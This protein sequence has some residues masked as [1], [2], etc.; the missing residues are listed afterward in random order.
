MTLNGLLGSQ[1]HESDTIV[2]VIDYSDSYVAFEVH[3]FKCAPNTL[4][5]GSENACLK[6][7]YLGRKKRIPL[8]HC[9]ENGV[10][11]K[12]PDEC[13]AYVGFQYAKEDK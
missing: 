6:H 12:Y 8:P 2:V 9:V 13:E 7:G 4:N 5:N 3:S 10:K 1:F 11:E